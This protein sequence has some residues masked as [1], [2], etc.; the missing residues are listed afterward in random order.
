MGWFYNNDVAGRGVSKNSPRKKPFFRFWELFKNKFGTL[1]KINLVYF[2]FCIPLVTFGPA[3]AAM[4]AMMR[5]IYLERPQFIFHDFWQYFKKNFKQSLFIGILDVIVIGLTV[6]TFGYYFQLESPDASQR[7]LFV[8][9]VAAEVLFLMINFY[10]YPQIAALDLGLAGIFK[11]AVILV[12]ANLP[13]ELITLAVFLG[14]G[15][16]AFNFPIIMALLFPL[17]P[18]A[19][20]AFLTV[21]C[22]YPAIQKYLIN[23]Y[24]E[25]SG[26]KNPELPDD[27]GESSLFHDMGGK[28]TPI[29]VRDEK[30]RGGRIIK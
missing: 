8:I 11:N 19:W 5:N 6:F 20:L 12:F 15:A 25:K 30:R 26:E 23:P 14:Y 16:L 18:A 29:D 10:V 24:Y 1:F 22:C 13:G 4:T 21:F 9:A 7:V 2:L 17:L 27:D 28:E 3:T